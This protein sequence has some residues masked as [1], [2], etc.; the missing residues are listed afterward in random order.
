MIGISYVKTNVLLQALFP[1]PK[2]IS[3][4]DTHH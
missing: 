2:G 1:I 4:V 3:N